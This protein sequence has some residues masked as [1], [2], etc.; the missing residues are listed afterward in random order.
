[1]VS[2]GPTILD[3]MFHTYEKINYIQ[4]L[5]NLRIVFIQIQVSLEASNTCEISIIQYV[6]DQYAN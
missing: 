3:S 4:A 2:W 1:M 5:N 6:R